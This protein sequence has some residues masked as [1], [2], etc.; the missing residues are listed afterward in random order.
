MFLSF[1]YKRLMFVGNAGAGKT[2]LIHCFRK[3]SKR[4]K[5]ALK[6][7]RAPLPKATNGIDIQEWT[8]KP[9]KT[10]STTFNA[11]DFAGQVRLFSFTLDPF[12]IFR[13]K[14]CKYIYAHFSIV[15][16]YVYIYIGSVLFYTSTLLQ[17]TFDVHRDIRPH[18]GHQENDI[19]QYLLLAAEHQIKGNINMNI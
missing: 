2:S 4:P 16:I 3:Q 8:A 15:C 17:P 13:N 18:E 14:K 10:E 9:S 19:G 5:K 11:W 6:R 7:K 1:I 12:L